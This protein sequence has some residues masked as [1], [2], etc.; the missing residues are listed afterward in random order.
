ME[1]YLPGP[2]S[3]VCSSCPHKHQKEPPV[4]HP[5]RRGKGS[6]P[7]D[8]Q[9]QPPLKKVRHHKYPDAGA[10]RWTLGMVVSNMQPKGIG[11]VAKVKKSREDFT[12]FYLLEKR[13]LSQFDQYLGVYRLPPP[14]PLEYPALRT[15][16]TLYYQ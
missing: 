8:M 16:T 4:Y 15:R 13:Y 3:M 9:Q 1:S 14:P 12:I 6:N 11:T 2:L 5:D 10:G 7:C